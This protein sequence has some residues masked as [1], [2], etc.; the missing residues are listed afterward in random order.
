MNPHRTAQWI[1]FG[2]GGAILLWAFSGATATT[3]TVHVGPG[4][5]QLKAPANARVQFILPIGAAWVQAVSG[6]ALMPQAVIPHGLPSDRTAPLVVLNADAGTVF[7]L[8][9]TDAQGKPGAALIG[10]S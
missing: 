5:M 8:Q 7:A 10:F 3:M 1:A 6:L 9:W 4:E 2:A